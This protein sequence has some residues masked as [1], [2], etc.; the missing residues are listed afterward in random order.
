MYKYFQ[1]YIYLVQDVHTIAKF[2]KHTMPNDSPSETHYRHQKCFEKAHLSPILFTSFFPPFSSPPPDQDIRGTVHVVM[3]SGPRDR[4]HLRAFARMR[5]FLLADR[6]DK[7]TP[8]RGRLILVWIMEKQN[9]VTLVNVI[10]Q[11]FVFRGRVSSKLIFIIAYYVIA[12]CAPISAIFCSQR[13]VLIPFLSLSHFIFSFLRR[14]HR[15][16][17][18]FNYFKFRFVTFITRM[19]V[20]CSLPSVYERLWPCLDHFFRWESR[21]IIESFLSLLNIV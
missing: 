6:Q 19:R 15:V 16:K 11:S 3:N 18:I 10:S 4:G 1:W 13:A 21:R 20:W 2:R 8:D 7:D 17:N 12:F 9:L 14:Q 5:I